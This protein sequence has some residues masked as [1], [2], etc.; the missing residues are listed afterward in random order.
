M[1]SEL[2]YN[3]TEILYTSCFNGNTCK[4]MCQCFRQSY[5]NCNENQCQCM[6]N[7]ERTHWRSFKEV[8]Y[9]E[10]HTGNKLKINKLILNSTILFF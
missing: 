7:F 6:D 8:I 1:C 4:R 9:Q 5:G 10:T 2:T 3:E